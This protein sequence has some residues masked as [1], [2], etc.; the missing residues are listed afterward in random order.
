MN[1]AT[2]FTSESEVKVTQLCSTLCELNC[3]VHGLY[4]PWGSLGQN[5]GMGSPSLLWGIFPTQGSNPGL[6]HYRWILYQLR[7]KGSPRLLEWVDWTG[8]S[9]TAGGFFTD[10]AIR[11]ACIQKCEV[12]KTQKET[13]FNGYVFQTSM[14]NKLHSW[15]CKTLINQK[16]QLNRVGRSGEQVSYP[17]TNSRAHPEEVRRLFFPGKDSASGNKDSALFTVKS[18]C[19][20]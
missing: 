19:L 4:S 5:T 15:Q 10:W 2:A 3:I 14:L 17:A 13:W 12:K 6:P 18:S 20:L 7:N 1:I 8:A 16:S 9:C 11:E